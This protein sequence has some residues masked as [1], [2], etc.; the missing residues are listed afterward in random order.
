MLNTNTRY[1]FL[2]KRVKKTRDFAL[3]GGIAEIIQLLFMFVF[4]FS[5]RA[6]FGTMNKGIIT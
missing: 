6:I 1:L 3:R 2:L 4:I 5:H